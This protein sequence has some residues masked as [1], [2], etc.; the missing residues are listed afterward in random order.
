MQVATNLSARNNKATKLQFFQT[1]SRI[2]AIDR[3][4]QDKTDR[5]HQLKDQIKNYSQQKGQYASIHPLIPNSND[6][7]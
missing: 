3:T 7:T 6:M 1:N 5:I 4:L 2:D